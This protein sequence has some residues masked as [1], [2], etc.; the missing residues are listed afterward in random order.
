[1]TDRTFSSVSDTGSKIIALD[2]LG[3]YSAFPVRNYLREMSFQHAISAL[4]GFSLTIGGLLAQD[5]PRY[6][7]DKFRQLD[8]ELPTPNEQRTASGAPGHAYWQMKADYDIKVELTEPLAGSGELPKVIGTETITYHNQSPDKLDYLWLQ[9]DGNIFEPG[10]DANLIRPSSISDSVGFRTLKNWVD[11]FDGGFRITSVTDANGGKLKHTINKTM[12]R[13]DLPKPLAPGSV[14]SFKVSWWFPIND[15]ARVGGRSGYEYFEEEDNY[16]F[17]IA[18]FYPRMCAYMDYS[19]WM[20]KQFLGQG[21]FTLDF[22]D[23]NLSVTVPSDHI[24]GATGVL[25]NES[26]V[27]TSEQRSRLAKARTADKPLM[28]VT[29]DEATKTEQSKAS[30]K[31]TWVFKSQNVRDVA[32]A[33]SRKFIWDGMNQPVGKHNVLCM[34]FYPKEGNPLWEQ[35]STK[36]VAHTIK[37]YSKYTIDYIYPVAISVH[38]DRIGMEY[39]MISFNGGRPEKDGTYS[40]RTKYGMIGVIIHEVGHNFFPMI[41]NSDERQ[42]T[43]M[44][45]GLNTYT[46]YLTE[47]EW[48]KDYPSW[49]G[50][51]RNIVGYMKGDK[52][53]IEPIMT[54]SENI[55][56]FGNNAYGK[57]GTALNIL[58]ETVMGRELFDHAFKTYAERWKFKHPT[59]ADFFRT[60]EDA[61]GVDLDWF[62]RGWFYTTDHVDLAITDLKYKRMDPRDP[63]LAEELKRQ[64]QASEPIDLSRQRNIDSNLDFVLDRD[65]A[66]RD[67]YNSYDPLTANERK[68]AAY[69]SWKKGLKPEE[70]ALLETDLHLYELTFKNIGGLV[71][72]VIL[73]W[74]YADG[75]KEV[76]RIPAEIWK[77]RDEVTKVFPKKKQVLS[78]TLD[79]F[80]E[81]ADCDLNNN[82]WPTRMVPT[83]FDVYQERER[84]SR[85]N[86]MQMERNKLGGN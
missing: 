35:Y 21:E 7:R 33:S 79:P 70:I 5:S 59:P 41:V 18:Q 24:V 74:E 83:R 20:H 10:S 46:Q 51:P 4:V 31:K 57:P 64:D 61:S 15:R 60:M 11:P 29:Q 49:R 45:E 86:P 3:T 23:Y 84:G 75:T 73:E 80:L 56:Q 62:W 69:D 40:D 76:E 28:I 82:S 48:D 1:M 34:S 66:T 68:V 44:D 58:R 78:V 67:F 72:P 12:M 22:G 77:T 8:Q 9:L 13:I 32:F 42:W 50:K 2:F 85:P 19:G 6:G 14:Y 43:W 26:A 37:T 81:T 36:V 39:P 47:Q 52:S 17:T 65:P 55:T 16:L 63:K 53:G 71:M 30:G 38:T 27:L 25:Q 54:S